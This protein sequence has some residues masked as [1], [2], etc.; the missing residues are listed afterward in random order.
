MLVNWCSILHNNS[1]C[2]NTQFIIFYVYLS[3]FQFWAIKMSP[4]M[5]ISMYVIVQKIFWSIYPR[6]VLLIQK[7]HLF[8]F[9]R[10]CQIVFQISVLIET[11]SSNNKKSIASTILGIFTFLNI[12]QSDGCMRYPYPCSLCL[13]WMYTISHICFLWSA[14]LLLSFLLGCLSWLC[15]YEYCSEPVI[16]ICSN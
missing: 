15:W 6:A 14:Y 7:I 5:N 3:A 11:P 12:C 1:L 13:H 4:Y 2:K 10:Q 16:Y 8:N 9:I